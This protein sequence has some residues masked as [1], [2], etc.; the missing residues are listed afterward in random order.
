MEHAHL[1][2][3]RQPVGEQEQARRE[4]AE[5]NARLGKH[6]VTEQDII[7]RNRA[8]RILRECQGRGGGR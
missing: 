2:E 3:N 8:E 4:L 1:E 7:R 5:A 6:W